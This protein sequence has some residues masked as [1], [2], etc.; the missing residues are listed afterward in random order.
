[1]GAL[2]SRE[3]LALERGDR[4]VLTREL[5]VVADRSPLGLTELRFHLRA[6][7]DRYRAPLTLSPRSKALCVRPASSLLCWEATA[8][9]RTSAWQQAITATASG[10]AIASML[11][12]GVGFARERRRASRD[13]LHLIRTLTHELRTPAMALGLD[14]EPLRAGYD[15]VPSHLQEPLLRVSRAI[16]RL[17]RVIHHSARSLQLFEGKGKLAAPVAIESAHEML[18]DFAAEWPEG[19]ALFLEGDDGAITTDP[20]WVSVALR[21]LVENAEKHGKP[22]V[23]VRARLT[24]D[25]LSIRV[26]DAGNTPALSLKRMTVAWTRSQ[27]SEGFGLGLALVSRIVKALGGSLAH[28][29]RPTAF[30][31]RI[32]RA[33]NA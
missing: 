23:V 16:A 21:N 4:L 2:G 9:R 32:P 8:P 22:P 18:R 25:A 14:I 17:H 10:I 31:I 6:T 1:L 19:V 24:P 33:G 11:V 12:L 28:E 27:K 20:E 3:W 13:R 29:A 7:W 15:D 26:E 30:V 5:L